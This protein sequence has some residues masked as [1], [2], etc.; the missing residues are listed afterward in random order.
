[1]DQEELRHFL[2][3]LNHLDT[4][5]HSSRGIVRLLDGIFWILAGHLFFLVLTHFK[6]I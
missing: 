1:M 6:V 3:N 2:L 4:I 5:A